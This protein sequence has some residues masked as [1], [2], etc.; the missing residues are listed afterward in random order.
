MERTLVLIKPDGVRRGLVGEILCRLERRGLRLAALK[1]LPPDQARIQR[2]Y[3]IHLGK[4]FYRGLVDFMTSGPI[5]ACVVEGERVIEVVRRTMGETDPIKALPG[6]IRG[7][8][9]LDIGQNVIHGSDSPESA[10]R[11]IPI[12]FQPEEITAA[13]G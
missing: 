3:E 6:T 4:S 13:A 9:A 5:V 2:L 8:L 1:M 7:D 12:F 11:E 10:Q